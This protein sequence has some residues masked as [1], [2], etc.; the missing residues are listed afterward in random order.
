MIIKEYK[1]Y[2]LVAQAIRYQR[3]FFPPLIYRTAVS[4]RGADKPLAR[5]A[6]RCIF[7][8]VRIFRLMLALQRGGI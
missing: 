6:S 2:N 7:F 1:E 5:P 8:M 4:Y 3:F